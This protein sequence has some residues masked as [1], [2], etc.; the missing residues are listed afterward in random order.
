MDHVAFSRAALESAFEGMFW[1]YYLPNSRCSSFLDSSQ[2]TLGGSI[3]V[4]GDLLPHSALL[5]TAVGAMALRSAATMNKESHSMKQQAIRLHASALQQIRKL[6]TTNRNN[7]LELLSAT[8][9]FSFY[10]V[11]EISERE[12]EANYGTVLTKPSM[13]QSRHCMEAIGLIKRLIIGTGVCIILAISHSR[14]QRPLNFIAR[15]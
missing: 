8:R 3:S 9:V 14:F 6:L 4:V 2:R 5:R 13:N 12:F 11:F 15:A 7:G 10:E 1:S